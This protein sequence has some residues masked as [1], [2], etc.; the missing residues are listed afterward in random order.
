M[1][2][3]NVFS[4]YAQIHKYLYQFKNK[5]FTLILLSLHSKPSS[6]ILLSFPISIFETERAT[7]NIENVTRSKHRFHTAVRSYIKM[8]KLR[9]KHTVLMPTITFLSS[10]G[11]AAQPTWLPVQAVQSHMRSVSFLKQIPRPTVP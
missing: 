9:T 7:S 6:R 10:F 2:V 4:Y 11:C 5:R 1:L 8:P 3:D